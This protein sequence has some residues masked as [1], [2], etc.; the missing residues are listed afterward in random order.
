MSRALGLRTRLH[1]L[2]DRVHVVPEH[3]LTHVELLVD[4]LARLIDGDDDDPP[5]DLWSFH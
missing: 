1:Q 2:A 3:L 5:T 4:R